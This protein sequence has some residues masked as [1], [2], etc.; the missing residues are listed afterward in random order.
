MSTPETPPAQ[1][2]VLRKET[3]KLLLEARL[4]EDRLKL[5]LDL[6]PKTPHHIA[7]DELL[8]ALKEVAV[9]DVLDRGVLDD[10]LKRFNKGEECRQRRIAKG[11]AAVNGVDGHILFLVKVLDGE[12]V[13]HADD[14]GR[15][16]FADL[17]LFDNIKSGQT[18]ARVYPPKAGK[19]GVDALGAVLPARHGEP[20]VVNLDVSVQSSQA[21]DA[22]YQLL[23]AQKEGYVST[24]DG[25]IAIKDELNIKGD[26]DFRYGNIDFVGT[27]KISG[28]VLPGFVVSAK[29]GI[30]IDGNVQQ[31]TLRCSEGDIVVRGY[32]RGGAGSRITCGGSLSLKIAHDVHAEVMGSITVAKESVDCHYL[33]QETFS[34][35]EGR[36]VGGS[37]FTV[38]G[39]EAKVFGNDAELPTEI[40]IGSS[41]EV[42][43]DFLKLEALI[44]D[45]EKA[46]ELLRLNLGPLVENP[47]RIAMLR[48]VHKAK[49]EQFLAKLQQ[50]KRGRDSLAQRREK[51]LAEGRSSA[52]VRVNVISQLYPGVQIR[53][54]D[55]VFSTQEL[56][57][58]PASIE[59]LQESN[60]FEKQELKGLQCVMPEIPKKEST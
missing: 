25:I 47:A 20:A 5:F 16:S 4:T 31:G 3:D 59:Y 51:M 33:S 46:L 54:G 43:S 37:L 10:I 35:T 50:V 44:A 38:C 41:V 12:V 48:G 56:I 7:I 49:M 45:H 42:S 53:R 36:V 24:D 11:T 57:K 19:D 13:L 58:G 9:P 28:D 52:V 17:N 21:S 1:K 23:K 22:P 8:V 15:V 14:R 26:L 55:A 6:I 2:T 32:A 18:I 27:V 60:T 34:A 40:V 29:R 30:T 39:A